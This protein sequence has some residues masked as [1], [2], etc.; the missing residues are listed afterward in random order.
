MAIYHFVNHTKGI[1]LD[2]FLVEQ[3]PDLSRSRIQKLITD[4]YATI[5][6]IPGKAGI[7]LEIG[8]K[9]SLKHYLLLPFLQQKQYRSISFMKIA[10]LLSLISRQDW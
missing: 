2:K 4:S 7:K 10:I 9:V 5:N 6:D 8:D 3:C 1:R